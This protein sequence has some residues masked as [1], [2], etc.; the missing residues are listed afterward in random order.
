M[1]VSKERQCTSV[2]IVTFNI[3]QNA[4]ALKNVLWNLKKEADLI[5]VCLQESAWFCDYKTLMSEILT[6]YECKA[7]E[8]YGFIWAGFTRLYVL[9]KKSVQ[10]VFTLKHQTM[11]FSMIKKP[12]K[13]AIFMK[14]ESQD[15]IRP[16][17]FVGVHFHAFE[18]VCHQIQRKQDFGNIFTKLF[19]DYWD[20]NWALCGDFNFRKTSAKALEDEFTPYSRQYKIKE[21]AWSYGNTYKVDSKNEQDFDTKR[22]ASRTDRIIHNKNKD[23]QNREVCIEEYGIA[24][25]Y[26]NSPANHS[27]H[28]AVYECFKIMH[29]KLQQNN[30]YI[31]EHDTELPK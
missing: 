5:V 2:E 25:P 7:E 22:I 31:F 29:N 30:W 14:C 15:F 11:C 20:C 28:K 6:E 10:T 1:S 21:H 9:Q 12:W 16:F 13:G 27:D 23:K 26:Q 24:T 3:N 18:G 8:F 4:E 19:T 17:V